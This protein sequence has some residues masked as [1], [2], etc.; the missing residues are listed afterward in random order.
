MNG[1]NNHHSDFVFNETWYHAYHNSSVATQA[2]IA[3]TYKPNLGLERLSFKSDGTIQQVT[4]AGAGKSWPR[5]PDHGPSV[6]A[7]VSSDTS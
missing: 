6:S 7:P 2:G 1:N 5:S 4:S 3:T